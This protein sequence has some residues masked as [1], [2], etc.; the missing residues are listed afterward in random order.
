M[1]ID[2]YIYSGTGNTERVCEYLA[3]T[4]QKSGNEVSLTF[5]G[6]DAAVNNGSDCVIVG[7]PVHAFNMPAPVLAFMKSLPVAKDNTPIYFIQTS[8]EPLGLNNA[9]FVRP[10]R[11]AKKKGYRVM[12]GFSYV[13]PYNII[14]KHSDGMAARMWNVVKLRVPPE[15]DII[16]G[17]KENLHSVGL[18]GRFVSFVLRVEHPAMPIVGRHFKVTKDCVGCGLCVR[19][20]RQKNIAMREGKP[21]FGKNCVGCMGCVFSCPKDAVRPSIF[22]GWRVNGFYGW[23]AA[24]AEDDEICRFCRKYYLKYFHKYEDA[25][26]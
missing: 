23:D 3:E 7:Y 18:F 17:K 25:D 13:M 14:F 20:C 16:S 1:K 4:L 22:N 26:E 5:L 6:K 21:V 12:G 9:A 24:P 19:Q 10:Q 8:G 15:A 11:I 2:F